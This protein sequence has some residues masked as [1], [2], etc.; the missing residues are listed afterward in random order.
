[1]GAKSEI[2][3]LLRELASKGISIL[4]VSSETNELLTLCDRVIVIFQGTVT[5]ELV[6]DKNSKAYLNEDNLIL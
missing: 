1:V 6:S 3:H 4:M 5:G 2:Y